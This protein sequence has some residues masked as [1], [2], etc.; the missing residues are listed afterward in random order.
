MPRR[1]RGMQSARYVISNPTLCAC[2]CRVNDKVV[3]PA[4]IH[5]AVR[6]A[7]GRSLSRTIHPSVMSTAITGAAFYA[8]L[9]MQIDV[10]R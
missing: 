8:L 2:I 6:K 10:S 1:K 5:F 4:Y 7:L 9:I 3:N